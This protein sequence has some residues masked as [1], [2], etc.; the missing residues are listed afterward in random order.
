[1]AKRPSVRT[2][3]EPAREIKVCREADVVVV[4]GGPGGIGSAIAAARSGAKTVLIERYGHLGGMAT[5]GLVNIIPN[6]SD[7]YGKQHLYGL[8]QELI[9]RLDRRGGTSYPKKEDWGTTDRKVV[10]YY[11]DA[12]LGWFHVRHDYKTDKQRVHYTAVVDPEILKD[13]L[14]DMVLEAGVDL[15]LH[16][17]G[18]RTITDGNTVR[19]VYFESKSGRQAILG[20]VIIDATGDGDIFVSAG[21]EMDNDCDNKRRTAWLALVFWMANVDIRK[22]DHFR[23]SQPDKWGELLQELSRLGGYPNFFK[24]IL[25]N[26]PGVLWYHCMQPQP[27]RTDAMDVEQLTRIDIKSRKRALVT[28]DFMKKHVPGFE[29]A[30]IM[31]TAPQLGTQ[32]G[33]RIVGEYT[34]SEKDLET[35]EVFPDTIA[36]LA[37]NDFGEISSNHPALCIPYRCLVPKRVDGLLVAGRA[38]S[39]A[40]TVNETF[41]IIPHCIAYGQAAGTAAAMAARDGIQPR[42]VDYTALRENLGKQ[43]VNL[44]K[45]K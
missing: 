23:A 33:R 34:L 37:N 39:S 20:K 28:Y 8:N 6:L 44:P 15:L 31:L 43:G 3:T 30:Y 16:S 29:N 4:G 10:D 7:I 12:N 25:R 36:V 27:E 40:D 18:T 17:W 45:I 32:G 42:K 26:Q 13:E 41:N 24:G 38:F 14:N 21:A 1:M 5:G 35:D 11:L 9:D 2:I 22:L 19:G